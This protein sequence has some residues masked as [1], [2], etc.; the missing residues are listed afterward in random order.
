MTN[1]EI[2]KH[3]ARDIVYQFNGKPSELHELMVTLQTN[4][5]VLSVQDVLYF[6]ADV[7]ISDSNVIV[8][9]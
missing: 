1:E 4:Y 9:E 5:S 6:I 2:K 8:L 7:E 3:F